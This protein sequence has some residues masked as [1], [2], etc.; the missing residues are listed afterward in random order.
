MHA[1]IPGLFDE[2][3]CGHNRQKDSKERKKGCPAPKPGATAGGCAFDGAMITLVPITDAAHVVHGPIACCGNSWD[4]RGS[5][6]SGP[7]IYKR[8][9]TTDVGENDVIMG[10]EQKLYDTILEVAAGQAPAAIFV[11]STCVTAL[12]GDDMDAVC[13]AAAEAT[14]LPV[15]PVHAAGFVGTKSLGN[16]LAGE[17]LLEHVIGTQEPPASTP[18]DINLIGEYNVAGELW[19]VLEVLDRIGIRVV[20]KVSGDA[21]FAEIAWAHRSR[22]TMVVCSKALLGMARKL[23]QRYGIPWF[24]GSFYGTR[25]MSQSIRTMVAML[26]DPALAAR[27]EQVIAEEEAALRISLA[28]YKASLAGRRAVLYTGGVKSWSIVSAM[29][30]LGM[31]VVATGVKK[32]TEEDKQRIAQLLGPQA[33]MIEKGSPEELLRITADTGAD[34]LVA[35]G[36][37]QYT[38]LK[39]RVPFLDIN[40][41]RHHPYAGYSGMVQLARQLD[42]AISSPVWQQVRR[43]APWERS[44]RELSDRAPE[45][46][47]RPG[48]PELQQH[49][50]SQGGSGPTSLMAS[51]PGGQ[52]FQD[53]ED[54]REVA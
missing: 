38:A 7:D 25:D 42:L 8:G 51:A 40:Q 11:Y 23:E 1:D 53:G 21:R 45:F 18:Y 47:R 4:G 39:G 20:S 17:A 49:K 28:P 41:E 30:D 14:G 24:E 22:L 32:S 48:A 54:G 2:P 9:L 3:T 44:D 29:Q 34:I 27:A 46:I 5:L 16:R 37:N 43:P 19:P 33:R 10:G 36:R 31:E 35:G 12:I 13:R 15:V 26:G 6:S 50:E 52:S